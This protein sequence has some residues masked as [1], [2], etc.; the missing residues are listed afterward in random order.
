MSERDQKAASDQDRAVWTKLALYGCPGMECIVRT[1]EDGRTLD[2]EGEPIP[3]ERR[4]L[5]CG[6]PGRWALGMAFLCDEHARE[7]ATLLE[8]DI[9]A[10][11]R[12]WKEQV[13]GC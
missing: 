12:A 13:R 2:H 7:T 9:D 4:P 3:F 10:I 8:D 1:T 5:T 11:D 6:K